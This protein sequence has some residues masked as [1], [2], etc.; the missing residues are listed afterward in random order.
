MLASAPRS[1]LRRAPGAFSGYE[2]YSGLGFRGFGFRGLGF[3]GLGFRVKDLGYKSM[4]GLC[5]VYVGVIWVDE[6]LK[7]GM[8]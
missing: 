8:A 3:R 7:K 4:K 6:R 5:R 1:S 2:V